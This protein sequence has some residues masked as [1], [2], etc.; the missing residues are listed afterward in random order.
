VFVEK[1]NA[2]PAFDK[3]GSPDEKRML[4]RMGVLAFCPQ[5]WSIG[6][7]F[8]YQCVLFRS[9]WRKKENGKETQG[10]QEARQD[11]DSEEVAG[12]VGST[13]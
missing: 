10:R 4:F 11:H 3:L 13:L 6:K 8:A 5:L 7:R 1:F 2:P 9:P 12:P